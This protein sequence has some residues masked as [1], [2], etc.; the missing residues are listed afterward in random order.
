[1]QV[2]FVRVADVSKVQAYIIQLA[3]SVQANFLA[4]YR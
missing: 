1:M 4:N 2:L 3:L